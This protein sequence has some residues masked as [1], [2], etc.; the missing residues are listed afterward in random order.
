MSESARISNVDFN[1]SQSSI[2]QLGG[3]AK[4]TNVLVRSGEFYIGHEAYAE[5]VT[6]KQ[7]GKVIASGQS[8]LENLTVDEGG[9]FT[10]YGS[11]ASAKNIV[12]EKMA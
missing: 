7:K 6:V 10:L 1:F 9:E 11:D 5:K 3:M 2:F 4:A 8:Q 12:I